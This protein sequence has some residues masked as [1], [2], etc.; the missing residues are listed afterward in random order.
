MC[1]D[2]TAALRDV[3]AERTGVTL[4]RLPLE[5]SWDFSEWGLSPAEF[6]VLHQAAVLEHRIF[7]TMPPMP[8]V[9]EALWRLSD[10][11][12][13]IRIITHRLYVNWGHAT[14][15]ADTVDWLDATGIPYR[16]LCFLGA[17][18]QVEADCYVEDAPHNVV[19]L[20]ENG[21]HVIV[22]EQPYNRAVDGPRAHD[23][24]G[25]EDL[26]GAPRHRARPVAAGAAAGFRGRL[27]PPAPRP[28]RRRSAPSVLGR[29]GSVPG[30][31]RRPTRRRSAGPSLHRIDRSATA[32]TVGLLVV[33]ALPIALTAWALLDAARRPEWAWALAGRRRVVWLAAILFGAMTLVFGVVVSSVY[34]VRVRPEI[35]AAESGRLPGAGDGGPNRDSGGGP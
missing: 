22:Y 7:R 4:D 11:G 15:V 16:D 24:T 8:G 30:P 28:A 10:A 33:S 5:R 6:E 25:V 34:L 31:R 12:V 17:K 23:W 9:A 18:P 27:E 3:V 19:A 1:G 32:S 13:W 26:V 35:D 2:Y 21:A 20:R 29:S 14:A